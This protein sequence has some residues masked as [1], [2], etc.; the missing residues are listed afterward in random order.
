MIE[1]MVIKLAKFEVSIIWGS[2][3]NFCFRILEVSYLKYFIAKK[4]SKKNR[5]IQASVFYNYF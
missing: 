3:Q 5:T 1:D 2:P 4:S